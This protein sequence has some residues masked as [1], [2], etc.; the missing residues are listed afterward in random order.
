MYPTG[1]SKGKGMASDNRNII[2]DVSKYVVI[3]KEKC[4]D[5]DECVTEVKESDESEL[6][7]KRVSSINAAF[8]IYKKYA[9]RK[10][11]CSRCDK[12]RRREGSQEVRSR[13]FCCS[14]Q[15]VERCP[16]KKDKTFIKRS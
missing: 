2:S 1:G 11:F 3:N 9:F 4:I 14:K 16:K 13:E 8:E 15:G 12:L 5:D 6:N 7:G 10:R